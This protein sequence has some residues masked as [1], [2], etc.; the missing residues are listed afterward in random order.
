MKLNLEFKNI[1]KSI[2]KVLNFIVIYSNFYLIST[3]SY[4]FDFYKFL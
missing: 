3:R 1:K 4:Y 2:F